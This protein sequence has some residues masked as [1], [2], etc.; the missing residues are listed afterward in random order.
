MIIWK[1]SGWADEWAAHMPAR[2]S[3]TEERSGSFPSGSNKR[4]KDLK[5]AAALCSDCELLQLEMRRQVIGWAREAVLATRNEVPELSEMLT[6]TLEPCEDKISQLMENLLGTITQNLTTKCCEG[7][8]GGSV[9]ALTSQYRMTNKPAPKTA[10]L[11]VK[12]IT[13]PLKMAM[14]TAGDRSSHGFLLFLSEAHR[15]KAVND[16]ITAV[17]AKYQEL[18]LELFANVKKLGQ[19]LRKLQKGSADGLSGGGMSDDDKIYLQVFLDVDAVAS[20]LKEMDEKYIEN[21]ALKSLYEV[22]KGVCQERAIELPADHC[23]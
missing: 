12:G 22:V 11:Y 16:I 6:K 23:M 15:V 8:V 9:R 5:F 14:S 21:E 18:V 13:H 7:L 4:D 1:F 10:S 3:T 2:I 19:T 20:S 17:S